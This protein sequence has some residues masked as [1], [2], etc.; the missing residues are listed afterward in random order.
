M[1]DTV[2]NLAKNH[3]M[4]QSSDWYFESHSGSTGTHTYSTAQKYLGNRSIYLNKTNTSS[5]ECGRQT[6]SLEK[7][8]TYTLSAYVKTSNVSESSYGAFI[9]VTYYDSSGNGVAA[10][11]TM[12]SG[13]NDWKNIV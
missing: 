2:V 13:T 6:L 4:E 5:Y 7:G 3:S 9:S 10:R 1:Q 8:K 12:L 11:S